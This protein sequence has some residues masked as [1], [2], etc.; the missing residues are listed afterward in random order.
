MTESELVRQCL[1]WLSWK[2]IVCWRQ[3][4][5]AI[6][7]PNGKGFRRFVGMRGVSDILCI[8]APT[9]RIAAI[10]CKRK[11]GRLSEDQ[12]KFQE[13]VASLGGV[14]CCVSSV[15]ELIADLKEA[16]VS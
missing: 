4:Q 6:P 14:A 11:G 5:G 9:G 8:L 3:N 13:A 15:E 16:G 2:G 7:L 12:E 10:E 1:E